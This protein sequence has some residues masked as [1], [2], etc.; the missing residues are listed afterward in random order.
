MSLY[1]FD[2]LCSF[3]RHDVTLAD[4]VNRVGGE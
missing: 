2:D 1:I 3:K 4:Q